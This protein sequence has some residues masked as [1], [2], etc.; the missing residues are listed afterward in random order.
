ATWSLSSV[1][2]FLPA[3]QIQ[4]VLD[5]CDRDTATGK[6]NYAILLLLARLGLRGGEVAAFEPRRYRLGGRPD[7]DPGQR[8]AGG[9]DAIACRSGHRDGRLSAPSQAGLFQS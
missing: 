7:H 1:P 9:T 8:Q 2:K 4:G 5:S 3:E 6:R